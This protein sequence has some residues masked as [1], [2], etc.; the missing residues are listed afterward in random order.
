MTTI[1]LT[2]GKIEVLETSQEV[3]QEMNNLP[4]SFIQL[5]EMMQIESI[6]QNFAI[7]K[8]QEYANILVNTSH[9]IKIVQH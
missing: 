2:S 4:D 1:E 7:E 3:I 8:R 6:S 9:I 5:N